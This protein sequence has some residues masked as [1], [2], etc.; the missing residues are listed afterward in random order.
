[1]VVSAVISL[2]LSD[3]YKSLEPRLPLD[4]E[5]ICNDD[6]LSI[7]GEIVLTHRYNCLFS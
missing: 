3:P 5:A 6:L 7:A 4:R 1:M 2:L